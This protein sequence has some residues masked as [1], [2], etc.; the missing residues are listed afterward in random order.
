MASR[1]KTGLFA[2]GAS[3][4]R[5]DRHW[6]AVELPDEPA[7]GRRLGRVS[8]AWAGAERVGMVD[9]GLTPARQ[10]AGADREG[11]RSSR[12]GKMD[13]RVGISNCCDDLARSR[14]PQ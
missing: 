14:F 2:H 8:Y 1:D 5:P 4:R 7:L 12:S 11:W 6:I 9:A 13:H 10:T 3:R